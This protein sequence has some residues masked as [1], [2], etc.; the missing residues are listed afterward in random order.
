MNMKTA[1]TVTPPEGNVAAADR[2]R[3]C[4]PFP[5]TFLGVAFAVG[6]SVAGAAIADEPAANSIPRSWIAANDDATTRAAAKPNMDLSAEIDARKSYSIPPAEIIGFDFLLNRFNRHN[7]GPGDYDVTSA[8]IRRNLRHSWVVDNDPFSVNQFLHPYQGSMYHGFARSAGL[9][10]W[11]ALGYTFAGSA[12]WEIAGENTLP[13]RN[14]QIASGIAG[15]FLGE[16]LFRM[17]NLVLERDDGLPQVWHELAAAAISPSTG[18]NRLAFGDRFKTIFPSRDPEYYSRLQ[19]GFTGTTQSDPGL[20]TKLKRN[21]FVTDFSMDYGLPGKPGYYYKRPFDYFAFETTLASGNGFE[22][23]LTR[24]LLIGTDYKVGDNY[25]GLW[26]LYGSYDYLAPQVFRMSSTALSL[27]TTGQVWLSDTIAMQGTGLLGVGYAA[28]GTLHGTDEHDYH[29]GVAPQ[30][31]LALRMIF[32][33]R[34][35]LDLTGREYLVSKAGTTDPNNNDNIAR[36]EASFTWRIT[37]KHAVALKYILTR[38]DSSY[39][40]VGDRSQSRG[41]IGIFYTLLGHD[42]FGAVDWR[43]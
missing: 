4:V 8:S 21:E 28:V 14:D 11:E 24:G 39:F 3:L 33:D 1:A 19:L 34:Y 5:A 30:A 18:F 22:S 43:P 15:T 7:E 20:S 10:Y 9:T 32:G 29:Y 40:S 26:G 12:M 42:R 27:G 38:R 17:A 25:R 2:F 35:S 31:L 13:S 37:G 41:T 6:V 36:A 23:I 16:S